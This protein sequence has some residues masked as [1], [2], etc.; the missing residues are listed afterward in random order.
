[1]TTHVLK[2]AIY[3]CGAKRTPFGSFGGSLLNHSATDMGVVAASAAVKEAGITPNEV[4][5]VITGN[6]VQAGNDAP[7]LARHIALK[8]GCP[9]DVPGVTLNR[10]CASGFEAVADASRMIQNGECQIVVASGAESM[11]NVP[12][13]V[14]TVR[15]GTALGGAYNFEDALWQTLC[16]SYTQMPMGMTAEKLGAQYNVTRQDCDEFGARSQH[17]WK[18]ANDDGRF[19]AEIA[20]VQVKNKKTK[21]MV[22]FEVDE[23]PREVKPEI[24]AKLPP[25]FKK[26]GIVTAASASGICDGG[27]ALVVASEEAV[28]KHKMKPLVRVH[29]WCSVGVD[30]TI[31]GF[32]PVPSIRDLFR[33]T[34]LGFKDMSY[35]EINEAFAAQC[36]ACFR[37]LQKDGLEFDK[38]NPNG[39]AIAK[40]HPVGCTGSAI[41]AH[42]THE[43]HRINGR[44]GLGS[45]CAGGG[46]GIAV[47]LEKM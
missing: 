19:K 10:L 3:I 38:L 16:D 46:M 41:L 15:F 43:L 7:Y 4:D 44:W 32:G 36:L 26:D 40:G 27:A 20:P 29:G 21:K 14:R 2:K 23:H 12:F 25:V 18:L 39:G 24:M 5:H 6:V 42:I 13:C 8:M 22:S 31:M 37:E 11:S 28:A 35:I 30:P 47:I 45:A 33:A 1:M 34:G 17:L 9:Q